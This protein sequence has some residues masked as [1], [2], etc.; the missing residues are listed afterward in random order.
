M[1]KKSKSVA[2]M[3][4]AYPLMFVPGD[5]DYK[6]RWAALTPHSSSPFSEG[7]RLKFAEIERT[8]R[9]DG[10]LLEKYRVSLD[11]VLRSLDDFIESRGGVHVA[12]FE[13]RTR[14]LI[15]EADSI[16][17]RAA[18]AYRLHV[19]EQAIAGRAKGAASTRGKGR[20]ASTPWHKDAIAH[21]K[22]LSA[23]GTASHELT[24]KCA[25]KFN[26]SDDAVRRVLQ[27][28]GL[29]PRKKK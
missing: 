28:A 19:G 15:D 18:Q 23:T 16:C 1:T 8:W 13:S 7:H 27:K 2:E 4:S 24:S 29:V 3:R 21:A 20:S 14:Q 12:I 6:E 11:E 25:L 10:L 26:K 9:L 22:V 17:M 5:P